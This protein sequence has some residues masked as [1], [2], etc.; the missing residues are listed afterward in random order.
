M[1]KLELISVTQGHRQCHRSIEYT[2]SFLILRVYV[3]FRNIDMHL[4]VETP[5]FF[6]SPRAP[7]WG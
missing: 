5:K 2:T 3:C 1:G 7:C 4:F 6:P